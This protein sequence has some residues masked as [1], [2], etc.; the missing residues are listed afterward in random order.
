MAVWEQKC[1]KKWSKKAKGWQW[2]NR[3]EMKSEVKKLKGGSMKQS[4]D[5]KCSKKSQKM[6]VRPHSCN[7]K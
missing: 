6:A 1:N 7:K 4:C 3:V 2:D 5:K